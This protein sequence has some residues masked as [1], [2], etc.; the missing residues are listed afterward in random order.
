MLGIVIPHAHFPS[1]CSCHV[2]V[3][4]QHTNIAFNDISCHVGI[5]FACS[6]TLTPPCSSGIA[7][8]LFTLAPRRSMTPSKHQCKVILTGQAL[9]CK[10]ILEALQVFLCL[11]AYIPAINLVRAHHNCIMPTQSGEIVQSTPWLPTLLSSLKVLLCP[12]QTSLMCT[13]ACINVN[14]VCVCVCVSPLCICLSVCVCVLVQWFFH[15]MCAQLYITLVGWG[16]FM[17]ACPHLNYV[18]IG[19]LHVHT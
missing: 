12:T 16:S 8:Y 10:V 13:W 17:Y 18:M 7:C 3:G 14:R 6:L 9:Q 5:V 11:H 2:N 4:S 1:E 15:A 19:C